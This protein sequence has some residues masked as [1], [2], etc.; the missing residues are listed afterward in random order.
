VGSTV[1]PTPP[2]R[3][4]DD[5]VRSIIQA[6]TRLGLGGQDLVARILARAGWR[7]SARS[8]GRYGKERSI[9]PSPTPP[10]A[11]TRR[12][13]R[14]VV[15]HFVNH[16]WMMDVSHVK[17]F[18]G[19]DLFMATVLDAFSRTP[20]ALQVF[21][22]RPS[23]KDMARLFRTATRLFARPKYMIT[24]RGGEFTATV[25]RKAVQHLGAVQRFASQ[26][27][28]YAT[29]RLERFWRTLKET[30][31]LYRFRLPLTAAD[32]EQRL[33]VTLLHYLCFRPHEGL[34]GAT[35]LEAFLGVEPACLRAVAPPRGNRGEAQAET[36]FRIDYLDP[37]DRRFPI[38]S[39]AA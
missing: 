28:L 1:K 17:Q 22:A 37:R 10:A 2:I 33:Q 21:A 18:L 20:L 4:A 25:F 30:A 7:V 32:L 6:M 11:G 26:D 3:R 36:P 24:D 19:P 38:L 8:V 31:G 29:A 34:R 14:P 35:P 16:V 9:E 5:V 39:R 23:A 15:A 13:T 27:N 12:Q